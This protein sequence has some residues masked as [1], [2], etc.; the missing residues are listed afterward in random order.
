MHRKASCLAEAWTEVSEE[1]MDDFRK[2]AKGGRI[3]I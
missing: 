2:A 1:Q 3:T